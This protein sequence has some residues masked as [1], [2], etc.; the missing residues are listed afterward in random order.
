[1]TTLTRPGDDR[2]RDVLIR[3]RETRAHPS[4]RARSSGVLR[5]SIV[6]CPGSGKSTVGRRLAASLAIPFVELDA[7]FH[8]RGWVELPRDQFRARV[9][10]VTARDAWLIDGNYS[11]VRDLVWARADT[12]VWL[13][14]PRAVV[15]RRVV[16]RTLR[17]ALTREQLWNGN[18][19][20]LTNLVR[21]D[22]NAS[23]IRWAWVKHPEYAARYGAAT[24]DPAFAHLH[25]VRL[26]SQAEIDA[27]LD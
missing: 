4:R 5:V 27:Y 25:F 1:V 17:R 12:V 13:D 22:P 11:A 26:G 6:G 19:E 18:R 23:I 16:A 10:D 2:R 9:A 15:I 8:Q 14:L 20:P 7:I 24:R 21:W 3:A